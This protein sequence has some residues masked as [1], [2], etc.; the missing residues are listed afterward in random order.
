MFEELIT[1]LEMNFPNSGIFIRIALGLLVLFLGLIIAKLVSG[2]IYALNQRFSLLS[3]KKQKDFSRLIE[4]FIVIISIIVS[5]NFLEIDAAKSV[6]SEMIALVPKIIIIFLLFFLGIILVNL[7]VDLIKAT[8]FRIGL[9]KYVDEFGI[10]LEFLNKLFLFAKLI[11]FLIIFSLSLNIAGYD[12]PFFNYLIIAIIL[13]LIALI[14]AFIFVTFR[15]QFENF[16]LAGYIEKNI[17]TEGQTVLIENKT[18]EV[19]SL[20]SH[21]VTISLPEGY[22]LIIP[23][24]EFIKE[25][26][27]VKRSKMD[28]SLLESLREKFKS[29]LPALCGPA[30]A[31][32][33]L[34]F[35]GFDAKQEEIAK[36]A[37]TK[38]PGGTGPRKLI[39]AVR[40]ITEGKVKGVLI[41]YNEITDLKSE[42][43]TW[44]SEGA[45]I[46]IWFSKKALFPDSKAK[47]HYSLCIGM[48][49]DELIIMDPSKSTAGVYMINYRLFEEAMG[50]QDKKRGY[51][52]FAKK[53]TSA[54]WRINEGL[55]Y[56]DVN[57]YKDLSKSFER[58]LKRLLR[59]NE[60]IKQ[61]L[62]EHIM[63][64]IEKTKN[65]PKRIWKP[66]LKQVKEKQKIEELKEIEEEEKEENADLEQEKEEISE[67]TKK[68]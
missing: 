47:G 41:K 33:L 22:N 21:G 56:A 24:K 61:I 44:L 17:L 19:V 45:L 10:G 67:K 26:I 50:G 51:L 48:E 3:E 15:D 35:F 6:V 29:Q 31:S 65:A 7:I 20:N 53:G 30:S 32:M 2:I 37:G 28:L 55:I 5:L 18:G 49:D 12:I 36:S 38:V 9:N 13:G 23:N 40:E 64:I 57:S 27:L 4:Y 46:I 42:I 43:I 11:L 66:N 63:E 16:F 52:V 8:L 58:Y 14:I 1:A 59:K 62:S 68:K 34:S 39:K 60:T 25:K 54:F